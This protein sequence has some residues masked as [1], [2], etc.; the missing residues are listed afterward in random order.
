[1]SMILLAGLAQAADGGTVIWLGLE[2]DPTL[3]PQ[4]TSLDVEALS[5]KQDFGPDDEAAIA[6]LRTELEAV[7]PLVD[8]FDGELAIMSRLDAAISDV[9]V[10]RSDADREL[11]YDALIFQGFAVHRYFQDQLPTDPGAAP[12]RTELNGLVT[13]GAWVDAVALDPD[14]NP[15]EAVLPD[16]AQKVAFDEARAQIRLA[17]RATVVGEMPPGASL[18][19]DG[20]APA[21]GTRVKVAPG[22]H[23][24]TVLLG[25]A[26]VARAEGEVAASGELIV[27]VG[28]M[29]EDVTALQPGLSAGPDATAIPPGVGALLATVDGPVHLVVPGDRKGPFVYVVSGNAATRLVE[30]EASAPTERFAVRVAGGAGWMYDGGWYIENF[31]D[32]APS[33]KG[34]VNAVT[35]IVH[36]GLEVPVGPAALGAGLDVAIPQGEYATLPTGSSELRVRAHPHV[37]VGIPYLQAT[38]G[39]MFPWHAAFGLRAH[40]PLGD[41]LE[42]SASGVYGAGLSFEQEGNDEPFQAED[43]L[44][45]WVTLGGRFG[46]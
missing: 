2:P 32:G 26:V 5:P 18:S 9:H 12:Y 17:P 38:A 19:V 7:R 4:A 46:M 33:E 24:V 31:S 1:M 41:T 36:A 39:Y 40:V 28:A 11:L 13:V 14:R 3:I 6:E 22:H 15:S 20:H 43:S 34:T 30:E 35:P 10:L 37:A 23:R 44:Q 25:D 45:A 21:G 27:T 16:D 29:S 42:A 8:E